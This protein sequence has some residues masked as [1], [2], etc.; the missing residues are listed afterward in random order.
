[1]M[2]KCFAIVQLWELWWRMTK[3]TV[4]L[5]YWIHEQYK[6]KKH[7]NVFQQRKKR[8]KME[9]DMILTDL[10]QDKIVPFKHEVHPS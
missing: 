3:K 1:M 9:N 2:V 6:R 4:K 5:S 8:W 7:L 10:E